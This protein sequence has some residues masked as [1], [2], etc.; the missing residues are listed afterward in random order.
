V[1]SLGHLAQEGVGDLLVG[2][3]LGKVD[4]DEQLLSLLINIADIDTTLVCE[5]NPVTL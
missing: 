2:R 4:G 5:K 3:V 1:Q